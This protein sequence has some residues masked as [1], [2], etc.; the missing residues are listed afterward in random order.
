VSFS[1]L[2]GLIAALRRGVGGFKPDK[3][4]AGGRVSGKVKILKGGGANS[5]VKKSQEGSPR[6]ASGRLGNPKQPTSELE[7]P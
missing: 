5:N 3:E 4:F 6:G 1:A 2:Y 7:S